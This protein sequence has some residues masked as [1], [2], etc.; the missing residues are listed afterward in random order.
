MTKCRRVGPQGVHHH[1]DV[2]RRAGSSSPALRHCKGGLGGVRRRF[3]PECRENNGLARIRG[4]LE[5]ALGFKCSVDMVS[6]MS[7]LPLARLLR[8]RAVRHGQPERGTANVKVPWTSPRIT[9]NARPDLSSEHQATEERAWLE[10]HPARTRVLP[11]R[12]RAPSHDAAE[13]PNELGIAR[14]GSSPDVVADLLG[15]ATPSD[16]RGHPR[17]RR[18]PS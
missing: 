16:H 5:F 1:T 12:P 17:L 14:N 15:R 18:H 10:A 6:M 4:E 8:D 2:G 9:K 3:G 13:D 7:L 11:G